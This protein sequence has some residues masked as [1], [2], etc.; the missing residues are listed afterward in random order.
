V[1]SLVIAVAC[2]TL[3]ADLLM[4]PPGR[5]LRDLAAY[6]ALSGAATA[7]AGWAILG[8]AER[9]HLSIQAKAF[10]TSALAAAVALLN[11][12]IIAQLMFVS[13]SHDLKLLIA[14]IAFSGILTASFGLW[15]AATVSRR[16][17]ALAERVRS[18][19]AGDLSG[20]LDTGAPDEVGKLTRDV[21]ALAEMLAAAEQ[22][23]EA[24]ERERKEL[25]AAISHDLRTPLASLRAMLE[26]VQDGVVDSPAE[27]ARYHE[28]MRR[29]IERLS[30]MIDDLFE[31]AQLDAGVLKLNKRRLRLDEVAAD[32]VHAMQASARRN[33]IDLR[34][35]LSG[36]TPAL[37]IDGTRIE[38]AIANLIRNSIEHTP[39]GGSVA[40][41]VAPVNG[42]V[43]VRVADNGEGIDG[44]DLPHIWDRFYRAEKSRRRD[45]RGE[46]GAGL[47]LAIV[48]G[49]VDAHGGEVMVDSTPSAGATFVIRL[50]RR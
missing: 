47:G 18:L 8:L 29:E 39:R 25:T 4:S 16:L 6:F 46:D 44:G 31:L 49:I 5:E 15:M 14:V 26:A 28:T 13:T 43:D 10:L 1:L 35:T 12:F 9:A 24:V 3:L 20:R 41:S 32:V 7:G 48:R 11:V 38:R 19:A 22:R 21:N 36:S 23:R 42:W 45:P 34:L 37:E 40:V 50:P 33:E 27:V 17:Q 2:G 30:R